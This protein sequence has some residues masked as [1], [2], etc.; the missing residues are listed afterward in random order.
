[1]TSAR[2]RARIMGRWTAAH[3]AAR[4]EEYFF[5]YAVYPY[6]LYVGGPQLAPKL[7]L[8][9][10]GGYWLGFG[11]MCG[12]SLA[13]NALYMRIHDRSG[14]DW[15]GF[16]AAQRLEAKLSAKLAAPV[17]GAGR[18]VVFVYLS[19]WHSPLFG[20]LWSRRSEAR[21]FPWLP[22]LAS[23]ALANAGWTMVLAGCAWA[24]AVASTV[25]GGR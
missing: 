3:L 22:F 11:A 25:W 12:V 5:D 19:V 14:E 18:L 17:R 9:R 10:H 16:E 15:F 24:L 6:A 23:V 7:G 4:A 1:M 21:R 20:T 8:P 13:L 2:S